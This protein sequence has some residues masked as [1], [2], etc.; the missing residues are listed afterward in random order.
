[1]AQMRLD[2]I[3]GGVWECVPFQKLEHLGD[4]PIVWAYCGNADVGEA[5]KD[6][7][8]ANLSV[9]SWSELGQPY[10]PMSFPRSSGQL[11]LVADHAA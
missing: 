11:L 6:F 3:S 1:M 5:F 10:G 7:V 2:S 8:S 9:D 4:L